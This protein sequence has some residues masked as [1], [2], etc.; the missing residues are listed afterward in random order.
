[1]TVKKET[2]SSPAI[3]RQTQFCMEGVIAASASANLELGMDGDG[4]HVDQIYD[5]TAPSF[6]HEWR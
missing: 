3:L 4:Q 5:V 2:Y 1:M 6:N